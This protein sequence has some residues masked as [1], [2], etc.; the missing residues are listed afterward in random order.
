MNGKDEIK[1]RELLK[2][3]DDL[4][5]PM[6]SPEIDLTLQFMTSDLGLIENSAPPDQLTL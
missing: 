2:T 4:F 6:P 5:T 3:I 1:L